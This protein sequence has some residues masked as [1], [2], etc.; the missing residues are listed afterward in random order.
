M[1]KKKSNNDSQK[2]FSMLIWLCL[3][4]INK[5]QNYIYYIYN[6]TKENRTKSNYV[7]T[8]TPFFSS[9][10]IIYNG[11][12]NRK[13]NLTVQKLLQLCKTFLRIVTKKSK[14]EAYIENYH[15]HDYVLYK[16]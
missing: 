9:I 5:T 16:T 3:K 6:T 13:D 11:L 10:S 2:D 7:R 8:E 4:A 12:P 14:K 15:I 1:K